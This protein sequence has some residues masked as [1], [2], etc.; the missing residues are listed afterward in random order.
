VLKAARPVGDREEDLPD[1]VAEEDE[2]EA[3][4]DAR[5]DDEAEGEVGSNVGHPDGVEGVL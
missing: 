3:S 4:G 1:H 2:V 5:E